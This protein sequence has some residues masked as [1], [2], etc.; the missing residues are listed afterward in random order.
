MD[1]WQVAGTVA[2]IVFGTI[3]ASIAVTKLLWDRRDR[4]LA[5][6]RAAAEAE[7]LNHERERLRREKEQWQSADRAQEESRR[8]QIYSEAEAR[9]ILSQPM[10]RD[11]ARRTNT[12]HGLRTG[13]RFRVALAVVLLLAAAACLVWL[14]L[15]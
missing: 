14:I 5:E 6:Q 8:L 13:G 11:E 4:H 1:A 3:G 15:R 10:P 9:A 12:S 7:T 2:A